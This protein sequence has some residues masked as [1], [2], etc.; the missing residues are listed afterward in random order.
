MKIIIFCHHN[1][2]LCIGVRNIEEK[3]VLEID[4]RN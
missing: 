4:V 3:E 1:E 2:K